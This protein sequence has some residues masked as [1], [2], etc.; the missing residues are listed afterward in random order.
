MKRK[1]EE[2]QEEEEGE[3]KKERRDLVAIF[4]RR[5]DGDVLRTCGP[6]GGG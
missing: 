2:E 1:T 5:C 4:V 3:E 6:R